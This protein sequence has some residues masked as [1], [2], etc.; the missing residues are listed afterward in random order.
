MQSLMEQ[1]A[2]DAQS[3]PFGSKMFAGLQVTVFSMVIVFSVLILLMFIIKAMGSIVMAGEKKTKQ[4]E[5]PS[6]APAAA[7]A[8]PAVAKTDDSEV[9]AAIVAAVS[10]SYAGSDVRIVIKDIVKRQDNW[11]T[12][13]L[14]EQMNS[15]L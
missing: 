15:R 14:L 2:I 8:A 5:I 13:G 7:V 1:L 11:G 6:A 10:S 4:A 9:V 3:L 12:V